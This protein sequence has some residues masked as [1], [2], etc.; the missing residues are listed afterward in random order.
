[1]TK[2]KSATVEPT[3]EEKAAAEA[4]HLKECQEIEAARVKAREAE[5]QA[6]RDREAAEAKAR[7]A[8][9]IVDADGVLIGKVQGPTDSEWNKAPAELRFE[10]GFDN[11][12]HRYRLAEWKPGRFRFEPVLHAKDSAAEN[13]EGS[14]KILAPIARAVVALASAQT[15]AA[16]DVGKLVDFLKSFDAQGN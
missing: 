13:A 14:P 2:K 5:E 15:P 10:N 8:I 16:S 3:A 9:A 1:M 6:A 12:F 7:R 4:A 11:A